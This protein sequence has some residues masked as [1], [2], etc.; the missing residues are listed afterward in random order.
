MNYR[1]VNTLNRQL[2]RWAGRLPRDLELIVG[3]PRSGLLVAN[4]LSL[5]LNLP[6]TDVEGLLAGR[7]LSCGVRKE[8]LSLETPRRVLVIDDSIHDGDQLAKVKDQ[9]QSAQLQHHV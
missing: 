3:V 1:S 5:H 6:L 4:L 7:V 2:L 9:I 8:K